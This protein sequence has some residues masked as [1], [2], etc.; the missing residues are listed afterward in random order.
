[1][2]PRWHMRWCRF[3]TGL[4]VGLLCLPA[5]ATAILIEAGG[6]RIGGY[7]VG[8]DGKKLTIRVRAADGKEKV[9]EYDRAQVKITIIHQLDGKRLQ[10]LSK[11]NPKAYRD[12]AEELAGQPADPE[13]KDMAMRLFLIA[14][15]LD[16]KKFGHSSLLRMIPLA[17]TP[18][19]ARKCRAMAFLLDAKAE[20]DLLKGDAVKPAQLAK[21]QAGALKNFLEALRHYRAGQ[22]KSARG[23]ATREGT[24]K[25]FSMAPGMIDQKAFLQK[26][27]DAYCG[28]C[29]SKAKVQCTVCQGQRVTVNM[30]GQRA[31]CTMCNVQEIL[32]S[33]DG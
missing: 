27:T 15:Y 30:F 11:D 5:A 12:Y 7:F 29:T 25:I 17:G 6:V 23:A 13:A 1:M 16:P 24:D 10:E 19:E 31:R 26:C 32:A 2:T 9:N 22:I 21:A 28:T 18:A 8:D 14:A 33:A 20:A 3:V 4:A